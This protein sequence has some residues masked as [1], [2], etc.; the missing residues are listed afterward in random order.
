MSDWVDEEM[1]DL[2]NEW[3]NKSVNAGLSECKIVKMSE[4]E[5]M[6]ELGDEWMSDWVNEE[7]SEWGY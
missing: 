2:A 5:K 6:S 7:I 4:D 3:M 1:G